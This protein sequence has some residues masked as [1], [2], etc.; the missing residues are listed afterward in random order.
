MSEAEPQTS[1]EHRVLCLC[2]LQSIQFTLCVLYVL[3]HTKV[4]G[5]HFPVVALLAEVAEKRGAELGVAA[6]W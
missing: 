1:D 2:F 6:L 4:G 3:V 5:Q